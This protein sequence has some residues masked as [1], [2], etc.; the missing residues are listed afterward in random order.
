MASRDEVRQF[1]V[2]L[3]DDQ[4][5]EI[6]SDVETTRQSRLGAE[7]LEEMPS[8]NNRDLVAEWLAG[9]H[10]QTDRGISEIWYLPTDAPPK[11]IRLLEVNRL[12]NL[13]M[14]DNRPLSAV[15]FGLDVDGL[16]YLVMV[17]D[18]TPRQ[19]ELI[20]QARLLLPPGWNAEGSQIFPRDPR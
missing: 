4:F 6:L 16:D 9:R 1:L 15:D 12:L 2:D 10:L 8:G 7:R 13:P 11:E 20:R 14:N 3:P 5:V 18:V 17:A 19:V